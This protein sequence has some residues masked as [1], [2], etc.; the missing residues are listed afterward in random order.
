[1][2]KVPHGAAGVAGTG[3]PRARQRKLPK[4]RVVCQDD[5][6]K[7]T[8]RAKAEDQYEAFEQI[9]MFLR[10]KGFDYQVVLVE[11]T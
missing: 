1:M 5:D 7:I 11:P 10:A 6:G 8:L 3:M 4:F 9:I 2:P